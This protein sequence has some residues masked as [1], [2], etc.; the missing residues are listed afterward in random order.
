MFKDLPEFVQKQVLNYLAANN[1]SG[2]KA[3]HNAWMRHKAINPNRHEPSD[4]IITK[5]F[6]PQEKVNLIES[7]LNKSDAD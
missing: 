2:A 7:I 4:K 3:L 6:L 5:N 1:F